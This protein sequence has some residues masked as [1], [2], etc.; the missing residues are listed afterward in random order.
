MGI[1]PF[2][3][4]ICNDSVRYPQ[5]DRYAGQVYELTG[6]CLMAFTEAVEAI[7]DATGRQV[8]HKHISHEVF[9]ASLKEQGVPEDTVALMTYLFTTVLD[10]R[11]SHLTDGVQRALGRQ[12]RDF[13]EY[14][15]QA[16]ASS[17]WQERSVRHD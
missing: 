1:E 9:A 4:L 17:A 14:V 2:V 8:R 12:P 10:G 16:A 6:P 11:N 13:S 3:C 5:R 15:R 7:A